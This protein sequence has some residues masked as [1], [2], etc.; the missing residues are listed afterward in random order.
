M[1]DLSHPEV[2]DLYSIGVRKEYQN[3][4]VN[5]MIMA[6]SLKS[7]IKH[8]V[9]FLETGPELE[10]NVQI[11]AQWKNYDKEQHRRRRCWSLKLADGNKEREQ[12]RT[13]YKV[14]VVTP[15]D[16]IFVGVGV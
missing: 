6:R 4:G 12:F 3:S 16:F 14:T 7:L 2:V 5:A 8:K 1:H 9:K 13:T 10:T 11:Q 15:R